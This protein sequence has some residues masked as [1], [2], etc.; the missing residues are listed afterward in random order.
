LPISVTLVPELF[1]FLGNRYS[2]SAFENVRDNSDLVD[3]D[4]GVAACDQNF[5]A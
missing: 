1:S 2:R 4:F 5:H 3:G